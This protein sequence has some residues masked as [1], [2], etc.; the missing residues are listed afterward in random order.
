MD[1]LL[2][3]GKF[4]HEDGFLG[5]GCRRAIRVLNGRRTHTF[6]LD[7]NTIVYENDNSV[8][9]EKT[10]SSSSAATEF[11]NHY[12]GNLP[13]YDWTIHTGEKST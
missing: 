2:L 4:Y 5:E 11:W 13:E 12:F 9:M 10:F 1:K 6:D 7:N 8:E 3:S